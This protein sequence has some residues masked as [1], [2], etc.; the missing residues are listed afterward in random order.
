MQPYSLVLNKGSWFTVTYAEH[1]KTNNG[2]LDKSEPIEITS[3]QPLYLH[4]FH[5]RIHPIEEL[6]DWGF[7]GPVLGPLSKVIFTPGDGETSRFDLVWQDGKQTTISYTEYLAVYEGE[8]FGDVT[9]SLNKQCTNYEAA[10]AERHR[11]SFPIYLE[12]DCV[13]YTAHFY[14]GEVIIENIWGADQLRDDTSG[15]IKGVDV[16][17]TSEEVFVRTM[18]SETF[19]SV[20][21]YISEAYSS[22]GW[23]L[24]KP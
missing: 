21:K 18:N 5:G 23:E 19:L 6:D 20:I 13:P 15:Q 10:F 17:V 3:D 16:S 22:V 12:I 24:L 8:Y 14:E 11:T 9:V 7:E 2:D 1:Q 4:P